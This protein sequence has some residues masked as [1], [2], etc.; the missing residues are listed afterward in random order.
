MSTREWNATAY[1]ELPLPHVEWGKRTIARLGLSGTERILDAGCGTG[2]DGVEL[3]RQFP[4]VDLVGVDGSKQMIDQAGQRL[5]A[6]AAVAV[7]DLT[8]PDA[9]AS[10]LTLGRTGPFDA[11]MSVACFHWIAEHEK[12]FHNLA[13]VLR[14]GGRLITDAGGRGNISIVEE[15]IAKVREIP[16]DP[17]T[18][19]SPDDERRH[20][21]GAGF[22]VE[23]VELRPHPIRIDDPHT[24]ER[25]LATVCLGGY[26][27]ALSE[28]DGQRFLREVQQ[29]MTEPVFDYVRLE[30]TA[31]RR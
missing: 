2:R 23:K 15:A 20:L 8:D 16:N 22:E 4:D 24:M 25:Y 29:A 1:D 28:E 6:S 14:P 21:A 5:G 19:A 30:I 12:L 27:E 3:L 9:V 17:K 26:L 10:S 13:G 18:F 31:T 11:V 7:V